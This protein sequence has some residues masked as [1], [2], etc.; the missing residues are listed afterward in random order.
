MQK[1]QRYVRKL[2]KEMIEEEKNKSVASPMQYTV[3]E[4]KNVL[5]ESEEDFNN[6]NTHTS[7]EVFNKIEQEFPWLCK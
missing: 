6:G 2:K 5:K 1:L 3:E 7:E 4:M